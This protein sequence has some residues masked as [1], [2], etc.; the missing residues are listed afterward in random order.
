[1]GKTV[2]AREDLWVLQRCDQH[3][4]AWLPSGRQQTHVARRLGR[5]PRN[6]S[7]HQWWWQAFVLP[8]ADRYGWRSHLIQRVP[9]CRKSHRVQIWVEDGSMH[10]QQRLQLFGG[11][12]TTRD[13]EWLTACT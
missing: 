11:E 13:G 12:S 4:R 5:N 3:W 2:C 8:R 9:W 6:D 10:P 7:G 1:M